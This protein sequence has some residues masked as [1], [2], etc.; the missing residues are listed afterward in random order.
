MRGKQETKSVSEKLA[1]FRLLNALDYDKGVMKLSILE[2]QKEQ[3]RSIEDYKSNLVSWG[4][5]DLT[6]TDLITLSRPHKKC[7]TGRFIRNTSM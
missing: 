6:P 4:V 3:V 7:C 1:P 2:S 5:D